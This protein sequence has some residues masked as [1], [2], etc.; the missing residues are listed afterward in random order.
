M[1]PT[2]TL[3]RKPDVGHPEM[4][5]AIVPDETKICTGCKLSLP[6]SGFYLDGKG[7]G[8]RM[9]RCIACVRS[10]TS[11]RDKSEGHKLRK[12]ERQR[13]NRER[14]EIRAKMNG[15]R[16]KNIDK[17]RESE[18]KSQLKTKYGLTVDEFD[19]MMARQ[20]YKCLICQENIS[21]KP[22]R[23]ARR[24]AAVDHDHSTGAVRGILCSPCNAGIGHLGDSVSRVE[25]AAAYL[26][27]HEG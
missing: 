9:A 23:Q 11:I 14:P 2:P 15:W 5:D 21:G 3:N 13:I 6:T 22:S 16:K 4:A 18:R 19:G 7:R 1:T 8:R 26:R 17:A 25:A 27:K 24:R 12:L 20:N 10:A